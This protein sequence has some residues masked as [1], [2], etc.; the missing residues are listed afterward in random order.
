MFF[1]LYYGDYGHSSR[2]NTYESKID[3]SY[4]GKKNSSVNHSSI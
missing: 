4:D 2:V 1:F 3:I